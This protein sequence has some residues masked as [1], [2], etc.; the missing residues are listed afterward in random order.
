MKKALCV[1]IIL[2]FAMASGCKTMSN[3]QKST[4]QGGAI[5]A[6]LGATVAKVAGEDEKGIALG[7]ALGATIGGLLA[8]NLAKRLDN[9]R[10]ALEGR[11]NNL[12]AR[13]AYA[14]S[15]N[16]QTKEYN[17]ELKSNIDKITVSIE[18]GVAKK[19]DFKRIQDKLN[20][21]IEGVNTALNELRQY[22]KTLVNGK[23]PKAKV[24]NLD[25]QIQELQAHLGNIEDNARKLAQL[26]KRIK[27]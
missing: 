26:K 18:K 16:I 14:R 7:A 2:C 21:D 24:D 19:E 9:E 20:E 6:I 23:H 12:D 13:I 17:E 4:L 8:Y 10:K 15:V 3:T 27:V 22:R 25:V 11:E 1:T 5:G